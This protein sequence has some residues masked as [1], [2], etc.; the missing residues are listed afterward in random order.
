MIRKTFKST[1]L[2]L[3]ICVLN[4]KII[5]SQIVINEFSCSNL[6]QYIDNHSD[7]NDWIEF[8]NTTSTDVN[9]TGFYLSDDSLNLSKWSFPVGTSIPAHGFLRVW[10]SGRNESV[11]TIHHTNFNL[12]QTKN[13]P[14]YIMLSNAS[15]SLIDYKAITQKTQLG[16]SY[17]RTQDGQNNWNIFTS[18]TPG[19]SNNASTPYNAYAS[20]PVFSVNAGFYPSD[21]IVTMTTTEPDAEIRYTT[22]GTL[23]TS[24]SSL[25]TGPVT[26]STTKVLKA[27]TFSTNASVLPGFLKYET[28]FINV[29]HTLPVVSISANS[30]TT[31]ANGTSSLR[32]HGTFEYFNVNKV[33]TAQTYG[34]FN[35]HGQDSWANSQRSLDFISRDE[36]GYN[37]SIEETLFNTSPRDKYQ[38]VILRAAGD[39]NYPADHHSANLGS[40]H[41]RDAYIHNLVQKGGLQLDVRRGSKCILY[42]N[43][44]YWGVYDLRDDPDNHDNTKY[45]YGQDKF[46]LYFLERWGNSWAQYGGNA[47]FDD[48]NSLYDFAMNNDMTDQANFQYVDDRLDVTSL[49]DYVAVNMFTVCTDWLNY[50]TGWWRGLDSSGTHLKWGFILWDNDATFDFYINYTGLPTTSA[51]ATPCDVESSGVDDPDDFI[52]LLLKLR[53]NQQFNTYYINHLVDLWNTV[54]DCDNMIPALDS[55]VALIDPEMTAHAARWNGTYSEWQDNVQTLRN[56]IIQRCTAITGGFMSCFN[57]TGPYQMTITTDPLS[58]GSITL[59]TMELTQF[60]WTGTFF[61]NTTTS[62]TANPINGYN[63]TNWSSANQN[64]LPNLTTAAINTDLN[65]TDTIVAHFLSTAGIQSTEPNSIFINVYPTS[66]TH[67]TTI[68]IYLPAAEPVSLK[69]FDSQGKQLFEI[70][71]SNSFLPAGR[72]IIN[73]DLSK[74]SLRS[75][76]Y[77]LS[78]YSEN[79]RKTVKLIYRVS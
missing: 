35:S 26:I 3:L 56:F 51:F 69:L 50:N 65:S 23:P 54:F 45:Y 58:S 25:Y 14:E 67:S 19:A 33:R 72:N 77:L 48:W 63:F 4:S 73:L 46:H 49:I 11:G 47:A 2:I 31:L 53:T 66:F 64:I 39:D 32:P 22:N 40:A 29:S 1:V 36:M 61:G 12:K 71:N 13:N 75:G 10:A 30:L 38:R 44:A 41:V 9:I 43:G 34:E 42:I 52:G 15:G 79:Y 21:V 16:H 28:Y 74:T 70:V 62:L 57:L 20:T 78:F 6:S 68:E 27:R 60:P 18:P 59:N 37:H 17:G 7:Y 5:N 76:L 24:S 8:Y 55:T